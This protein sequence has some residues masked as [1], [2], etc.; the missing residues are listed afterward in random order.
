MKLDAVFDAGKSDCRQELGKFLLAVAL[1]FV[2]RRF[3]GESEVL[4]APDFK[5]RTSTERNR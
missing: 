3:Q 5:N 2:A 4:N 1:D